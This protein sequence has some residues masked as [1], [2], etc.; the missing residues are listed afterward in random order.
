M[1]SSFKWS[2]GRIFM[3]S[4]LCFLFRNFTYVETIFVYCST[5]PKIPFFITDNNIL[6][7]YYF[8]LLF[9]Y[10]Y[11]IYGPFFYCVFIFFRLHSNT[12]YTHSALFRFC[13]LFIYRH[14]LVF[15]YNHYDFANLANSLRVP[16]V[17]AWAEGL[18]FASY[19]SQYLGFYWDFFTVT[20]FFYSRFRLY[21]ESAI[22]SIRF[23]YKSSV[24]LPF[25]S[26]CT[27]LNFWIAFFITWVYRLIS[28]FL[29]FYFFGGEGFACDVKLGA[30]TVICVET[31]LIN[32]RFFAF[33]KFY[34]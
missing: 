15:T 28:Y 33:L 29:S 16:V 21:F 13:R 23:I 8:L 9:F 5:L 18:D 6:A 20:C 34:K 17:S 3:F 11:T 2:T 12:L 31:L 25:P 1:V 32:V 24:P 27:L 26:I 30:I 19:I 7:Y 4:Y 10:S 14:F 22:N